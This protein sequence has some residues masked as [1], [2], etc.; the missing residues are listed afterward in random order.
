MKIKDLFVVIAAAIVVTVFA[1][2]FVACHK[3]AGAVAAAGEGEGEGEGEQSPTA[4]E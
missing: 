2:S 3:P 1:G 4:G